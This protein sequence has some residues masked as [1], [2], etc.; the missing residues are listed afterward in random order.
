MLWAAFDETT[1]GVFR[2]SSVVGR[3]LRGVGAVASHVN[4]RRTLAYPISVL[5]SSSLKSRRM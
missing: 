4:V 1:C 3:L 5:F 2:A